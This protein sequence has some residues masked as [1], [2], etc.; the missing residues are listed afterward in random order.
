M[1]RFVLLYH[2]C[3]PHFERSSHWDLM[4]ESGDMLRTWALEELPRDWK[5]A[6]ERTVAKYPQ[7]RALASSNEVAAL[8]LADHRRDF[9]TFEGELTRDRGHVVRVA[10]GEYSSLEESPTMWRVALRDD[11]TN[12]SEPL[13]LSL[14]VR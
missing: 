1:P 3:P 6:Y 8:P 10:A 11:A 12:S 13:L 9:L 2:D 5:A 4:L 14:S 7:C